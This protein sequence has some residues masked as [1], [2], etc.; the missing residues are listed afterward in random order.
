MSRFQRIKIV[1]LLLLGVLII[2]H[3]LYGIH[4]L[5]FIAVAC[6]F[7]GIISA[8]AF[9]MSM[10]LFVP[11]KY[12]GASPDNAIALTFDDGPIPGKTEKILK[13][14]ADRKL[15]AAFFCI[16][17]RITENPELLKRIDAEGHLIGN[18]TF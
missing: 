13:I 10:Q 6:L 14:L 15:S 3:V 8:G 5:V 17:S 1:T 18:H 11:V 12:K 2:L 7:I 4:Y 16:G 9:I